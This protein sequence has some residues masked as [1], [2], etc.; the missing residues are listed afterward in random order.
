M[1]NEEPEDTTIYRAIEN[2]EGQ[3]SIW[4]ADRELLLGW[5]DTGKTGLKPEVLAYIEQVWSDMRPR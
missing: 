3:Y 2:G 1:A 4:P 5:H